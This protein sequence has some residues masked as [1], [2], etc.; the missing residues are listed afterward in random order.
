MKKEFLAMLL[1]LTFCTGLVLPAFAAPSSEEAAKNFSLTYEIN[2]KTFAYIKNGA[3]GERT[4][5]SKDMKLAL[6]DGRTLTGGGYNAVTSDTVFTA[7]H[8]GTVDD[9]SY[10][11]IHSTA[12][13]NNGNGVYEQ[14]WVTSQ[15]RTKDGFFKDTNVAEVVGDIVQLSA[16][17][18]VQFKLPAVYKLGE[19]EED[20]F[21]FLELYLYYPGSSNIY[22]MGMLPFKLDSEAVSTFLP[23]QEP[24]APTFTDVPA[25]EWYADPVAWAVEKNITNGTTATKFS[26][27]QNC[28]HAQILTL[29][30]RAAR[31]GGVAS[32]EDMDKAVEWAREKD[33]I[34]NTFDGNKGCTRAEAVTI[35]GRRVISP[36]P[37]IPPVSPMWMPT[38]TMPGPCPG[39]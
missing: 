34:D 10:I 36:Q 33:M 8:V 24:T 20:V 18:S 7:K 13:V 30:Y 4:N 11:V 6:T 9:G 1:A 3:F 22:T 39:R 27:G 23:S 28:T 5:V 25:G 37:R 15:V 17:Q 32:A 16:G 31:D 35:S 26:P 12:F 29:L 38:Q 21:Y 19:L 14:D 2:G